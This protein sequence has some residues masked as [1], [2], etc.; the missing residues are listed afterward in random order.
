[1]YAVVRQSYIRPTAVTQIEDIRSLMMSKGYEL[2][3][4]NDYI[5]HKL[6]L[7]IED[8]HEKNVLTKGGVLFFINTVIYRK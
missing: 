5:H 6:G 3:R 8:L 1:M 4:S 7:I 2:K